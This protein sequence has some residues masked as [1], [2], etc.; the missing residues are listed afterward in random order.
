MQQSAGKY[1]DDLKASKAEIAEMN[2][3]IMRLQSEID[4]IK[5]QVSSTILKYF[6]SPMDR[7][8]CPQQQTYLV[9]SC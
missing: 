2:R 3:R 4:M 7:H 5:A 6:V 1:G 8:S 9:E